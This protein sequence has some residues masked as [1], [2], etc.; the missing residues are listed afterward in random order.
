MWHKQRGRTSHSRCKY[1]ARTPRLGASGCVYCTLRRWYVS[2]TCWQRTYNV[3]SAIATLTYGGSIYTHCSCTVFLLARFKVNV[4]LF[5]SLLADFFKTTHRWSPEITVGAALKR[6]YN[7]RSMLWNLLLLSTPSQFHFLKTRLS[8][9]PFWKFYFKPPFLI[10]C[11]CFL[12]PFCCLPR[13]HH[14]NKWC[15]HSSAQLLYTAEVSAHIVRCK[16]WARTCSERYVLFLDSWTEYLVSTGHARTTH[17]HRTYN[18]R[19]TQNMG[20]WDV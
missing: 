8:G 20:Q 4:S 2:G 7:R 3:F 13:W 9:I 1:V 16:C 14:E 19:G 17:G 11:R 5:R 12:P 10:L 6:P 15:N 18:V